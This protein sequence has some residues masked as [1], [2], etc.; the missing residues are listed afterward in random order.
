MN[1]LCMDSFY[2]ALFTSII[3]VHNEGLIYLVLGCESHSWLLPQVVVSGTRQHPPGIMITHSNRHLLPTPKI[4]SQTQAKPVPLC[5]IYFGFKVLLTSWRLL[6]SQ[7]YSYA[8]NNYIKRS[9]FHGTMWRRSEASSWHLYHLA[10]VCAAVYWHDCIAFLYHCR[11]QSSSLLCAG[12]YQVMCCLP[13]L[14][15]S[16]LAVTH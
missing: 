9:F 6:I 16:T 13:A 2:T 12:T 8:T 1:S 7:I 15:Y 3:P 4:S 10:F 11:L 14:Y 5:L